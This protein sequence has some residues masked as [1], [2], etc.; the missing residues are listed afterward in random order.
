MRPS[1]G[2]RNGHL[3][4]LDPMCTCPLR[5]L[6]KS[7]LSIN[8]SRP[9]NVLLVAIAF[10]CFFGGLL[11]VPVIACR[12]RLGASHP[13]LHT[14]CRTQGGGSLSCVAAANFLILYHS[15]CQIYCALYSSRQDRPPMVLQC[16]SSP[17]CSL[18]S[19]APAPGS[20]SFFFSPADFGQ[21]IFLAPMVRSPELAL[22]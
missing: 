18:G 20:M 13:P 10:S 12:H 19:I 1:P 16:L 4:S 8:A 2:S 3:N 9:A 7:A 17:C 14:I 6:T 21:G 11:G 5:I 22:Q 15:T